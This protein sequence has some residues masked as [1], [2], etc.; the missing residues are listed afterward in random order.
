MPRGKKE[1]AEQIIPYAASVEVEV[2]R[3]KTVIEAIKKIGVTEQTYYRW[4]KQYGGL[5]I[6]QAKRLKDLEKENSR[7]KRLLAD[8][9]LDYGVSGGRIGKLLSL[10]IAAA[11]GPA[12][13]R[14][15]WL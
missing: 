11:N 7:L 3:G 2:V 14:C 5:R 6:D 13:Q 8:A 15:S 12:R 1:L 9:E 10:F 4:K